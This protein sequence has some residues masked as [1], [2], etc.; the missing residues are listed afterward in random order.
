M[1]FGLLSI[2]SKIA[3][4]LNILHFIG[5]GGYLILK[6][7]GQVSTETLMAMSVPVSIAIITIFCLYFI[8]LNDSHRKYLSLTLKSPYIQILFVI[9]SLVNIPI[10]TSF[11]SNDILAV[12]YALLMSFNILLVAPRG[13]FSLTQISSNKLNISRKRLITFT[14]LTTGI[15]IATF[16]GIQL[17]LPIRNNNLTINVADPFAVFGGLFFTIIWFKFYRKNTVWRVP[18]FSLGLMSF[19][20]ML[21]VGAMVAY[22]NKGEIEQWALTN[23]L[24]G[25]FILMSYL[26]AGALFS[27]VL[28]RSHAMLLLKISILA[29]TATYIVYLLSLLLELFP[30]EIYSILNWEGYQFSG[31]LLNKNAFSLQ[32]VLLLSIVLTHLK[33]TQNKSLHVII[34]ITIFLIFVT[35]SRTAILLSALLPILALQF[36][37]FTLLD[38]KH[39]LIYLAFFC[40]IKW[41]LAKYIPMLLFDDPSEFSIV[42]STEMLR[43]SLA[44]IDFLAIQ[45]DRIASSIDGFQMWLA[46]PIFGAG[47]GAYIESQ[48]LPLVIHNSLLWILAEMGVFG[49]MLFM[50]LPICLL[51]HSLRNGIKNIAREDAAL[52]LILVTVIVFS[53][54]HEILYQRI[55]WFWIGLFTVKA[56]LLSAHK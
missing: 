36:T 1:E 17:Q 24:I 6:R 14:A 16:I 42:N 13:I 46:N 5:M 2:T 9:I 25:F 21:I 48:A 39:T 44:A 34:A 45:H 22:I 37:N 47:L 20:A 10:V 27:T 28:N 3:F 49:L 38:L 53:Q 19:L 33:A 26:A 15:A 41:G 11:L 55:I 31:L 52:F 43:H 35:N 8:I 23:R 32:L 4:L 51:I 7:F 18:Y 30:R 12:T 56:N 29:A 50:V 40:I 54:F